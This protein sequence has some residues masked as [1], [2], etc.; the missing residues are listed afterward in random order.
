MAT[1]RE[2]LL[3]AR[4]ELQGAGCDS[5]E[6]ESD[7]LLAHALGMSRGQLLAM[8]SVEVGESDLKRF[9]ELLARRVAR[10]PLAYIIGGVE[11]FGRWISV[12]PGVLI[13]RVDTEVLV[14]C[15]VAELRLTD[16]RDRLICELGVGSGCVLCSI[17]AEVD[18]ATGVGVD[19]SETALEVTAENAARLG[20]E[21]RVKLIR[22]S[23]FS[24]I[25]KEHRGEFTIIVSNP[26]Y[27]D[28][29]EGPTLQP[30]VR[31]HEPA[32]AL[33]S[34][35]QGYAA[36]RDILSEAHKWLCPGG[37]L[38]IEIGFGQEREVRAMA[39]RFPY[40]EIRSFA[41]TAGIARVISARARPLA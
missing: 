20:V 4:K 23:W 37:L 21:S 32:G 1:V 22:S 19:V 25:P 14:E 13:P 3:A 15:A 30:E 8:R 31:D 18:S 39:S 40:S 29:S 26:P 16:R 34:A 7:C 10:E 5:P 35:D 11:F 28:A 27:I 6:I 2:V 9:L 17:L 24:E 12:R 41:D 38:L 36:I 33:F